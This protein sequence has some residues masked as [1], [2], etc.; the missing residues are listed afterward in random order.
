MIVLEE[1]YH[2]KNREIARLQRELRE[3]CAG[4]A[5]QREALMEIAE[6][7]SDTEKYP[8]AYGQ[9]TGIAQEALESTTAGA[10]LLAE[11]DTLRKLCGEAA[12]LLSNLREVYGKPGNEEDNNTERA[13]INRLRKALEGEGAKDGR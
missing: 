12:E 7:W 10:D 5:A 6:F 1:D 11:L 8:E 2:N 9:L 13:L 4:A 3:A